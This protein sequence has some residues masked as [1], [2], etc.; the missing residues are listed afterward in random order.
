MGAQQLRAGSGAVLAIAVAAAAMFCIP[1][2][3]QAIV[4]EIGA[5]L[6]AGPAATGLT[7]TVVVVGIALGAWIMGPLSDRIGRRAVMLGSC[8]LLAVPTALIAIDGG[9]VE[10]LALRAVQGLLLPG[11]LTVATA[12][13]YEAFPAAR[14]P[15][16]VGLYTSAL[17]L[18][19]FIG[20]T[21]PALLVDDIGWRWS[22]ASLALPLL[23]S[24]AL[25]AL[26]LPAAPPPPRA[27]SPL[28]AVRAHL[29]NA[30]ILLNG[31]AAGCT[32]FAFVG[33]Y[34]VV[35]YR[36]EGP[37][38]GLSAAQVGAFYVVWLVGALTPLAVRLAGRVGPRAILPVF[39]LIGLAGLAVGSVGWLP[40]V[41]VGLAV[42]AGGLFAMVGVA[43]LLV[44]QLTLR[45]RGS[46]MSVHLTI[47]YLLGS[48]GP[49]VLGAAWS[50]AGWAGAAL[51]AALAL[52]VAL[53]LTL[54]LRRSAPAPDAQKPAPD[55]VLS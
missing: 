31:L 36:L 37:E 26:L 10:L 33:L 39:P 21:V 4:P 44:P 55:P 22:L 17:V 20:R 48:L 38:F 29:G 28:R 27:R 25:L 52:A 2:S 1:Y 14:V 53:V 18:G 45:D 35:A 8:A 15:T 40:A 54:L 50:A 16:V 34:S 32:F 11:L 7:I 6:G 43:Q 51:L 47:Y 3:T 24:A 49:F 30:P 23:A 19:G 46:A 12:Y 13:V 42:L 5:D 9:L 41:V